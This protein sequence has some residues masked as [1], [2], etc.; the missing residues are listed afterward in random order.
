MNQGYW[1]RLSLAA[2]WRLPSAEAQE[3]LAD[4][5][6]MFAQDAR[7]EAELCRD[8]GQPTQ[9]V[10]V[11]EKPKAYRRWLIAFWVLTACLILPALYPLPFIGWTVCQFLIY[12]LNDWPVEWFFLVGGLALS[13]LWFQRQG[14]R[15]GALPK[16]ILF[17][18]AVQLVG[19]VC[20]GVLF[21]IV[22]ARPVEV[23]RS[24]QNTPG[25][26]AMVTFGLSC[27]V[28]LL[29]L[30]GVFGLIM[31]RLDDRRWRA[32]YILGLT[33]AVLCLSL[34]A[35]VGSMSL[36]PSETYWQMPYLQ[37]LFGLTAVGLMGTGASL[38]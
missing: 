22:L 11:L 13:L 17:C 20:V 32:V 25:S 8:L 7:S 29:A 19:V 4:Y 6:D 33:V 14:V 27:F 24:F 37:Q 35:L 31:A 15:K 5:K 1:K 30:L 10:R 16:K 18:L 23:M 34:L 38:C 28:F 26:A 9:V 3:V 12:D 21:W 36:D 2:R